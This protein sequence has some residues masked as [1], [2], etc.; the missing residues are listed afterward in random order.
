MIS[1]APLSPSTQDFQHIAPFF[2]ASHPAFFLLPLP[3][4]PAFFYSLPPPAPS[5]VSRFI[6]LSYPTP[7]CLQKR[8]IFL[9]VEL[10]C[11]LKRS[12]EHETKLLSYGLPS[13]YVRPG[14]VIFITQTCMFFPHQGHHREVCF[15][16]KLRLGI[17]LRIYH[18][19]QVPGHYSTRVTS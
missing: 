10:L 15:G 12:T 16:F 18:C 17:C 7:P 14:P 9:P 3:S 1:V 11:M 4:H 19:V 5:P 2:F 13:L 8:P 6:H